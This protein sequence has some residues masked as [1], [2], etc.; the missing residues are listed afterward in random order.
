MSLTVTTLEPMPTK[1]FVMLLV[2]AGLTWLLVPLPM[3]NT[4]C[5]LEIVLR[6]NF[7]EETP[8]PLRTTL[9]LTLSP[10]EI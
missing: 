1:A 3:L 9:L 2:R 4:G 8:E 6:T 10:E 5:P 7:V